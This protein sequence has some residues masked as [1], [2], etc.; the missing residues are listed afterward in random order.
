MFAR[1]EFNSIKN[2]DAIVIPRQAL[3]GSIR[4][5]KVF[6]V[7][8]DIAKERSVVIGSSSNTFVQILSG[9]NI[10]EVIVVS[11]QNNLVDNLKV[12]ILNK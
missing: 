8:N 3:V 12:E 1:V 4:N 6:V 5:P 9:L 10:G 2:R 7:E 11:G